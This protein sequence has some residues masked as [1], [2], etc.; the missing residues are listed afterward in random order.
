[1]TKTH[2]DYII[3]GGGGA[4]LSLVYHL[5]QTRL[6][7]KNILIIDRDEKQADDRTWC[8][9]EAG[10]GPFEAIVHHRW[11]HVYFH[12]E[13][14]SELLDLSP[15]RYKMI[16]SGDYYQHIKQTI[17]AY[18]NVEW[19]SAEVQSTQET[20]TGA[21]VVTSA[22]TFTAD[23]VFNSL[24]D[25]RERQSLNSYTYLLQHFKGWVIKT[26][27][28]FFNP[29]EATL[30]DFRIEQH[31]E[32]RFFYVLPTDARTALVEFTLFSPELLPA[33]QYE[34]ALRD[35]L[36][37]FLSLDDYTI[38]H[39]EFGVIPMTNKP[40]PEQQSAHVIN[41]GTAGGMTKPSTGYTFQRIQRDS[42][43]LVGS[44]LRTGRPARVSSGWD[45]RFRLYDS[46][47]FQ[48]ME[49]PTYPVKE[50]F[51]DL[52]RKNPA[53]RVLRFLDE[54]SSF[55]EELQIANSVNRGAFARGM[56]QAILS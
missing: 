49:Q 17:A 10:T 13:N 38:A 4:G 51:T 22:G 26:P 41:I 8:F 37:R 23:W 30:M 34:V 12:G 28:D 15:Y 40:Y 50:I 47:L 14:Y 44:L 43:Q 45:Q 48:V 39:E 55:K 33:P 20:A 7:Q 19:L 24:R 54:R 56:G 25:P 46:T 9:W 5:L 1:M 2:Y 35:Y 16:R 11:Q 32:C 27:T 18:P 29:E 21:Q 53:D 6:S 42:E 3:A 52:F 31:G 36:H